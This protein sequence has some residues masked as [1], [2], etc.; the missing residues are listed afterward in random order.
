[1]CN[2]RRGCTNTGDKRQECCS[3]QQSEYSVT[4]QTRFLISRIRRRM[5]AL[6]PPFT[7]RCYIIQC[8]QQAGWRVL[9][10]PT[11][12]TPNLP[13]FTMHFLNH[14]YHILHPPIEERKMECDK[15]DECSPYAA[16]DP[17]NEIYEVWYFMTGYSLS[18]Y[19]KLD[20]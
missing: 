9:R 16:C 20:S 18:L 6:S 14:S 8:I 5:T 3:S 2:V 4:V 10:A 19:P 13:K 15:I 17:V 11:M 1:M 7:V 12:K